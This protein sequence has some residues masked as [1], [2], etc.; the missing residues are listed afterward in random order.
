MKSASQGHWM[1]IPNWLSL[2]PRKYAKPPQSEAS[3]TE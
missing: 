1:L 2:R 3:K